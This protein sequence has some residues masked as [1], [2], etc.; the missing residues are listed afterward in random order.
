M[1]HQGGSIMTIFTMMM[2]LFLIPGFLQHDLLLISSHFSTA[3]VTPLGKYSLSVGEYVQILPFPKALWPFD[4]C[5][6]FQTLM[7]M[8]HWS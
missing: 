6:H 1:N 4:G 8:G 2:V 7:G 5:L 3:L